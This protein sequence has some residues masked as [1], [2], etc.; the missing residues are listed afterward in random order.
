MSFHTFSLA[1]SP[2]L[3]PLTFDFTNYLS[4]WAYDRVIKRGES[5]GFPISILISFPA[6]AH[7]A[8]MFK[9]YCLF[10]V[11]VKLQQRPWNRI[12][13]GHNNMRGITPA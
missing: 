9:S 13:P 5:T 6:N 11:G 1:L 12:L 3:S 10:S 7:N 2:L 4:F 8:N